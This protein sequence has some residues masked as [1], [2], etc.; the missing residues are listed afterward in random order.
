MTGFPM[1]PYWEFDRW[2]EIGRVRRIIDLREPWL[3]E[4]ERIRGSENIPYD[5]F[6]DHMGEINYG[7]IPY[8]CVKEA[9]K[10]WSSAGTCGAWDMRWQTLQAEW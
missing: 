10:A 3:Y 5:E 9:P 2:I 8:S 4:E 1:L 6:W 7:E